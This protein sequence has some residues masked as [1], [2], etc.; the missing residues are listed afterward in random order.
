V[1]TPVPLALQRAHVHGVTVV[2]TGED[3][4]L[5]TPAKP[6]AAILDALRADKADVVAYLKIAMAV[7]P[8]PAA[9]PPHVIAEH[10]RQHAARL[11]PAIVPCPGFGRAEWP[12]VY[13]TIA[14]F[15]NPAAAFA[16]IAAEQ[17]WTTLKLFG[18]HRKVG[19]RRVDVCGALLVSTGSP[20]TA[21][22]QTT[23]R[24]ANGLGTV[25]LALD[26]S[27]AIAVWDFEGT[28]A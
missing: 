1:T 11:D 3:L 25:R 7:P 28:A 19:A 4:R 27:T 8:D 24:F 22:S 12:R 21:V 23:I 9:M 18:V 26:P 2:V 16:R 14:D 10:W 6:P 13:R 5:V 17:H 15:L 20:V